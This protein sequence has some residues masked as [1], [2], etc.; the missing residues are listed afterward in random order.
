VGS[1]IQIALFVIPFIVTLGWIL[2]HPLSLYFDPFESAALFLSVVTVNYVI[3]D[4]KSNWLEGAI[5]MVLYLIIAICVFF[6]SGESRDCRSIGVIADSHARN[7][8][9]PILLNGCGPSGTQCA[10]SS[11]K[12]KRRTATRNCD[13]TGTYRTTMKMNLQA[14]FAT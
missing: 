7:C 13:D 2:G 10:H 6:Y 9:H 1:S 3:A 11:T 12:C 4:G 8:C 14:N 5:L